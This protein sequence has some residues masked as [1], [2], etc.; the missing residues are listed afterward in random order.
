MIEFLGQFYENRMGLIIPLVE[1]SESGL[2]DFKELWQEH[3]EAMC[4]LIIPARRILIRS[5]RP[6]TSR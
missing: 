1:F 5:F 6:I 3:V 2:E 4:V